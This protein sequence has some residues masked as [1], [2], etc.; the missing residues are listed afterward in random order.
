MIYVKNGVFYCLLPV[1]SHIACTE[2]TK[3]FSFVCVSWDY[4]LLLFLL[5]C[6]HEGHSERKEIQIFQEKVCTLLYLKGGTFLILVCTNRRHEI[7][8]SPLLYVVFTDIC[9][10]VWTIRILEV[11]PKTTTES[12]I[13]QMLPGH[14]GNNLIKRCNTCLE[15]HQDV[16]NVFGKLRRTITKGKLSSYFDLKVFKNFH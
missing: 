6:V 12:Q 10:V 16:G 14:W 3:C 2:P 1:V 11:A 7:H 13:L 8:F 9:R 15:T 5:V 4:C